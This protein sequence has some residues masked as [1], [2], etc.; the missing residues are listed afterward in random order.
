MW[1]MRILCIFWVELACFGFHEWGEKEHVV[2]D[3]D[4]SP[5]V[6]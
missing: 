2:Q 6:F 5:W 1:K 3:G 4:G